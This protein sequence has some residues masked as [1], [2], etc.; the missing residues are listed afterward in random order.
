MK[1]KLLLTYNIIK[2]D[3]INKYFSFTHH[4]HGIVFDQVLLKK[5]VT[6]FLPH[7]NPF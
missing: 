5:I 1:K 2:I 7:A 6:I 3:R 4:I